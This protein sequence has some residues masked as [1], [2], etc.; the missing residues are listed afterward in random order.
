MISI[1]CDE[2]GHLEHDNSNVMTI[3]GIYLPNYAR[4]EVYRD[5]KEIKEKNQIPS[6]REI[7]WTKVSQ[8]KEQYYLDLVNYFFDNEL[9]SFRGV[10]VPNKA[11]LRHKD[12]NQTHDDFYYK[13]YYLTL[14]KVLDLNEALD[15][16]ID[17]KDTNGADKVGKLQRY[18]N[19]KAR[20]V[21]KIKKIQQIRSHENS[22]LQLA[23]LIIGGITYKNRKL[24]TNKT[25][26]KLADLI[27][28]RS[29]CGITSKSYFSEKKLNLL[30]FDKE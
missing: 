10:V 30:F 2:S 3:G 23:D 25:K 12:F 17:I 19:N 28:E 27:H 26:V 14:V 15:I 5:I 22:I 18:L 24:D 8:A 4:K 16:Y 11:K 1:Y 20:D 21:E 6:H 13:M 9:L 7:K 29:N